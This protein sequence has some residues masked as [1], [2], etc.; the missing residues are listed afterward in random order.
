[1]K[2]RGCPSL[3]VILLVS[4]FSASLT[5]QT[6]LV[7]RDTEAIKHLGQYVTVE[8]T[9]AAVFI[10]KNGNTFLSFGAPYPYQTFAGLILRDSELAGV[11]TADGLT[12]LAG[13]K[14]RISGTIELYKGKPEIRIS[15][16]EQ[17]QQEQD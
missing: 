1:M 6:T 14:L 12:G 8:G 11:S 16:K 3:F 4:C 13:K 9:V 15:S 7:I 17:I 2:V 10:S 5:A